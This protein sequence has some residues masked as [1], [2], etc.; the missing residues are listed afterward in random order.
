MSSVLHA[1]REDVHCIAGTWQQG[2]LTKQTNLHL[3]LCQQLESQV[4][5]LMRA[6]PGHADQRDLFASLWFGQLAPLLLQS[7]DPAWQADHQA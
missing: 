3:L 7:L 5:L 1:R 6:L 2:A 4:Q